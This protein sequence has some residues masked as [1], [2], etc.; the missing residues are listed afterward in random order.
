M[1]EGTM[2]SLPRNPSKF[3]DGKN[4]VEMFDDAA[5][6]YEAYY[7]KAKEKSKHRLRTDIQKLK[8]ATESLKSANEFSKNY[9]ALIFSL[10]ALA[11]SVFGHMFNALNGIKTPVDAA[12]D[13][14]E[15]WGDSAT[16]IIATLVPQADVLKNA[17]ARNQEILLGIGIVVAFMTIVMGVI[18][19][20]L[21]FSHNKK[22]RKKAYYELCLN[23]CQQRLDELLSGEAEEPRKPVILRVCKRNCQTA[24]KL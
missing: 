8:V 1:E 22:G 4:A 11:I 2:H 3:I 20:W 6:Q 15:L 23:A 9:P 12:K 16:E 14:K 10:S 17:I 21:L 7:S 19:V 18:L 13:L 24:G 5:I